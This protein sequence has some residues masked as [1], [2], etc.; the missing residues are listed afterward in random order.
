MAAVALGELP[1]ALAPELL[2]IAV[3]RSW[4]AHFRQQIEQQLQGEV[5]GRIC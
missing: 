3:V 4:R 2:S 1:G 5:Y